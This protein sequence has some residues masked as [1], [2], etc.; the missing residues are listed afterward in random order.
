[1]E[2]VEVLLRTLPN[3]NQSQSGF[4]EAAKKSSSTNCACARSSGAISGVFTET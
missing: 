2:R 3:R 4:Q 1:M